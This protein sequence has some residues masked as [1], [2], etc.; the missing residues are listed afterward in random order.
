MVTTS[1]ITV[2]EKIKT[3]LKR[4]FPEVFSEDHWTFTKANAKF[5]ENATQVFRPKRSVP[6]AALNPIN[7][8][9]ERIENLGSFPN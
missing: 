6:F 7:G 9:L 1:N 2:T 4:K 5:K 3:E 8:K